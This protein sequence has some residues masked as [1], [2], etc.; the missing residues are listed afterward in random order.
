MP[1]QHTEEKGAHSQKSRLKERV[2][3]ARK[4]ERKL[5]KN[6]THEAKR[7]KEEIGERTKK[8]GRD[9]QEEGNKAQNPK[10]SQVKNK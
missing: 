1:E 4:D 7:K 6:E 2:G 5:R 3:Q 9:D 10:G 8:E